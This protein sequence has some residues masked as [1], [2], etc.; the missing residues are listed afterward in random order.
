MGRKTRMRL[1]TGEGQIL[2]QG[3]LMDLTNLNALELGQRVQQTAAKYIMSLVAVTARNQPTLSN[4]TSLMEL[5]TIKTVTF[6]K[7]A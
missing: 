6:S 2:V 4:A 3:L 1:A 7:G 5:T